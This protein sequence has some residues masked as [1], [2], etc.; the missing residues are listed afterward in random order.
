MRWSII[1]TIW[2]REMR[3]QL[4]DRRTLFMIVGLPLILYPVLGAVVLQFAQNFAEKPSVIGIVTGSA[5]RTDFPWREPAHAGRSVVSTLSWLAATPL[6]GCDTSQW[7]AAATL[8][9]ASQLS[10]DYP[11]LIEDGHFTTFDARLPP[12]LAR[13]LAA[14][15]NFKLVFLETHDRDLLEERKVDLILEAAPGF[16]TDVEAD[17]GLA[18]PPL[19]IHARRDDSRSRQAITRLTPLLDHWKDDLVKVRLVRKG[20]PNRFLDPFETVRPDEDAATAAAGAAKDSIA[21][22]VIRVFPFMLVM[23]SLAG[24]LYPAVDVCAGEKE[25]GTMET[26]LITPAGREEIVLG[27]F[28]T[29]WVFSSGTALLNLLSMGIATKLFVSQL[30]EAS[31]LAHVAISI[32]ALLWCVLLSLPQSAFFSALGLAIGAMREVPRRGSII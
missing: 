12:R 15:A 31:Q 32:P 22:M 20:L 21:D 8:A 10:L 27:K 29:I 9:R 23:W 26:L 7:C 16:F 18:R 2:L 4:R 13:E 25:R 19:T 28:L 11:Q 1:R 3:D 6:P 5:Q 17:E 24:A 30:Q 14:N